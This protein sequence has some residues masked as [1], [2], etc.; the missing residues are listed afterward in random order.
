M[1]HPATRILTILELLQSYGELSGAEL[2]MKLEVNIRTVRRYIV[3]LQDMGIPVEAE[4]GRAGSYYLRP[5]FKLPPLM[6]ND[7]E[8]LALTLSL[9]IASQTALSGAAFAV[10]GAAAKVER[11][12]PDELRQQVHDLLGAMT[13]DIALAPGIAASAQHLHL[14][15]RAVRERHAL[16]LKHASFDGKITERVVDPY[17]LAYRVGRWY[18]VGYC[19]LREDI[20]TFRLDRVQS[21]SL[22]DTSFEPPADID[23]I[24]HVERAIAATPGIYRFE[25]IIHAPLDQVERFVPRSIGSCEVIENGVLLTGF[26]QHLDWFAGFL[27]GVPLPQTILAPDSLRTEMAA[28]IERVRIT[29]SR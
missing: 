3:M 24:D 12:L 21:A 22:L 26:V 11:V 27:S 20:R 25:V 2:A 5:G 1:V 17:G 7:E 14:V 10:E 18:M 8:A 9:K 23:I 28:L 4:R 16:H 6:F 19:H 15:G 13:I 29:L